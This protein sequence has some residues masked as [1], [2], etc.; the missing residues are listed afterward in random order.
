MVVPPVVLKESVPSISAVSPKVRVPLAEAVPMVTLLKALL[1]LVRV[2]VPSK[3]T[4]ELVL[5][6]VSRFEKSRLPAKLIVSLDILKTLVPA[7]EA[8]EKAPLMSRLSLV[9]R[10]VAAPI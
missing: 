10:V 3:I 5:V 1:L 9:E 8:I 2:V 4:V 7:P 6:K